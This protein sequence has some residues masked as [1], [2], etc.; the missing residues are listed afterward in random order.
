MI[1]E[2]KDVTF[3]PRVTFAM[4]SQLTRVALQ[5]ANDDLISEH[6]YDAD[7]QEPES[8]PANN[9]PVP[10]QPIVPPAETDTL[11][12]PAHEDT[13]GPLCDISAANILPTRTRRA[14]VTQALP[15]LQ[16]APECEKD[17]AGRPDE[18]LWIAAM[19][20]ELAS[21]AT[22]K[23]WTPTTLE[24]HPGK[25]PI[26]SKWT[27][28][29]KFN[30]D[31]SVARFKARLVAKGYSQRAGEDYG[32]THAPVL[33]CNSLRLL[34][35]IAATATDAECDQTD[36][37]TAFLIP[38]LEHE[39]IMRLTRGPAQVHVRPET[40]LVLLVPAPQDILT[41][42]NFIQSKPTHASLLTSAA[43]TPSTSAFT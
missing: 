19:E 28:R 16:P 20:K 9:G 37:T 21:F 36:V 29:Y 38:K 40:G 15:Q 13:A 33:H 24:A 30:S 10:L 3:L 5:D 14:L 11:P 31:G 23:A 17:I 42:I 7:F 39:I 25:V 6:E 12:P 41:D 43:P 34:L 8:E 35:S 22:N 18:N 1:I 26:G 32:E 2:S 4:P 27:F